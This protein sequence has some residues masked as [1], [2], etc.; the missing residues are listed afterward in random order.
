MN[1]LLKLI[2]CSFYISLLF[3]SQL[4]VSGQ[5]FKESSR[6]L[7]MDFNWRFHLGDVYG[8]NNPEFDDED[9]R[10]LNVPH[11]YSIEQKF[12][13]KYA[14][15]SG[16][17]PGGIGWYRKE[18]TLRETDINKHFE[19][20]FD[21][22][23]ENS[24]VWINGYYLGKRSYGFISFYYDI[25]PYLKFGNEKNIIAVRV[26]NSQVA[27]SRWY[28]GSGI[29]RHV[30]LYVTDKVHVARWGTYITTPTVSENSADVR[31]VTKIEND[32]QEEEL[33]TL[34]SAI[35]DSKGNIAGE[36]SSDISFQP[37][38][39]YDYDQLISI[40]QPVLWSLENPY[41]YSVVSEVYIGE[42]LID[43]DTTPFGIRTI[44]F[45]ADKGFFLNGESVKIKGVCLH[46]D[47]GSLGSAI[48]DREWE[49]RLILMK[50]MGA[51]AVRTSH[52]P[53]T[54][55][56][57]DLCDRMGF[58]V[59]DEAFD[60]WEIGKKK[61]IKG[62]N[63]GQE[64]GAAGLNKYYSQHGYSDHFEEWAKQDIQA[65]VRRDRNH[66]SIVLWSI[67][68]EIDY[69]NDPY[70]DPSRENFEQWRPLAY[71]L[72]E[73]A[74]DLY[75]YVKEMDT[76]RPVTA[77]LANV[78]L[79]NKIG[80]AE[81]LDVVGYNYQEKYYEEDHKKFPDRK[82][83]GSENGDSYE[84]W[85]AVK[86]NDFITG[87]FLWTGVD[88]L[89]EAGVF[90]NRSNL[91]GLVDLS[92]YPKPSF[93]YRQS[94]WI[95][96]P[97]V[98]ITCVSPEVANNRYQYTV[99][100]S[101]NWDNFEGRDITVLGFTNCDKIS[102]Y[103]NDDLISTKE[104]HDTNK[105]VL[106][107]EVPY[108]NGTLKAVAVKDGKEAAEHILKTTGKPEKI[109][110]ESGRTSLRAD[111]K[112]FASVKVLVV[113]NKG[114]IVSNIDNEVTIKV[115]G[116]GNNIGFGNGDNANLE[117]YKDDKHQVFQGKARVFIQSNGEKGEIKI[118]ASSD[119]LN[120][121]TLT[122]SAE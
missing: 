106:K 69:P 73:I 43:K 23:Y 58:L 22:V 89:G 17:L 20:Q 76:T 90:P 66:P 46:N 51:N 54:P 121:G 4:N 87:Q 72:T 117:Y 103:L 50:E 53:T 119:G 60:E 16:F 36:I 49:R 112:D 70:T 29:Y 61:W 24:E 92:D 71:Q 48:P 8:A 116:V 33:V 80:Y 98:H 34:K 115:T 42:K 85:L 57:L 1:T 26:D 47:A 6:C 59:M 15:G 113:D 63:V 11:D 32:S 68:N 39:K 91:A 75:D 35:V 27:D 25:T 14:S 19:I 21:G 110:L 107:W 88:Y 40:E 3:F 99:I 95:D 28:T 64:E 86:N 111:G 100:D 101:W 38:T 37:N 94:L 7:S 77:A 93:Y 12:S 82:I 41:M 55:E 96:E 30:W 5:E 118:E 65:M 56:L 10:L 122:I 62:W 31:I 74:S 97:M 104:M 52:N 83:I 109:H 2:K 44:K 102:L 18:F 67:G 120:T 9:W 108:E 79:S 45:D 78:P 84:A 81:I 13:D 114:S 105:A